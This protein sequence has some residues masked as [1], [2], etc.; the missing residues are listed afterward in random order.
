[1]VGSGPVA[2]CCSWLL[3]SVGRPRHSVR[4][5]LV[6]SGVLAAGSAADAPRAA[7]AESEGEFG[8]FPER[9]G[10]LASVRVND[11]ARSLRMNGEAVSP[12]RKAYATNCAGR[13]GAELNPTDGELRF[14]GND[15]P[16][17]RNVKFPSY[18]EWT[19]RY[20]IRSDDP[21]SRGM[22]ADEVAFDAK[23]RTED[24]TR[25]FG[26]KA[27]LAPEEV[28]DVLEYVLKS[29][30]RPADVVRA[31]RVDVLFHDGGKGNCF[32]CHRLDGTGSDPIGS[33][34]LTRLQL[35]LW[36]ERASVRESVAKAAAASCRR[37][38]G[39][40]KTRGGQ[41]GL[42]VLPARASRRISNC[43]PV[44]GTM[45]CMTSRKPS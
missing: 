31:A 21:G 1:M 8:E 18:G 3:R 4:G 40:L 39:A 42:R 5:D 29:S 11:I 33:T 36:G 2:E 30:S 22:E 23:F 16:S 13:H 32:D 7:A 9:P 38:R 17:G 20:G 6:V 45:P 25:E 34:N 12:G 35:H 26:D 15:L 43:R 10:G 41:G 27:F 24:D 28:E 44:C 14:S 19:V 37:S